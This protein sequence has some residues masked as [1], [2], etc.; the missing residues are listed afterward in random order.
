M[1]R[2]A[3]A[4]DNEYQPVVPK[5]SAESVVESVAHANALLLSRYT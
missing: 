5:E 2:A 1:S 3:H 4:D